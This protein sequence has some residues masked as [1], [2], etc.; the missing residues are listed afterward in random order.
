MEAV[1]ATD[2]ELVLAARDG[3][4]AAFETLVRRHADAVYGHALRFFRERTAAE[5]ASQEVFV[6]V[7]RSLASFDG[8]SAFSTWL[9]RVT[10]NVCLD[11]ARTARRRPASSALDSAPEPSAPSFDDAVATQVALAG[12]LA[13][14]PEDER[15][16]FEA[17]ALFGLAYDEAATALDA[18]V[19]TVKSRVFRARRRLVAALGLDAEGG[20]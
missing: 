14:I 4:V 15:A 6:K 1:G 18:P 19:G 11:L 13:E 10:R 3:D 12:A 17:V 20:A 16:A 8:R 5:D 9:F 2:R 7:Y